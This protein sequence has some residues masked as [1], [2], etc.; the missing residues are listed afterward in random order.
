VQIYIKEARKL[1]GAAPEEFRLWSL[2]RDFPVWCASRRQEANPIAD[3]TPW[4][5]Y[6]AIRFLK[7]IVTKEMRIYEYGCG[8]ST[9]FFA[10][11]SRQVFA[12]EHDPAWANKLRDSLN[13]M[14]R[15]NSEIKVVEPGPDENSLNKDFTNPHDYVSHSPPYKGFDFKA[16]AEA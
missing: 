16:Y 2:I 14:I 7:R 13:N 8:G 1:K 9:I 5:T 10:L 15:T 11:R 3:Q 12:C 6:G 4:I